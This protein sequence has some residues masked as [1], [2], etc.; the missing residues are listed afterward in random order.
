MTSFQCPSCVAIVIATVVVTKFLQRKKPQQVRVLQPD[1]LK[2]TFSIILWSEKRFITMRM[3]IL[4]WLSWACAQWAYAYTEHFFEDHKLKF[5][6]LIA[7]LC[8]HFAFGNQEYAN[9]NYPSKCLSVICE[10]HFAYRY[11]DHKHIFNYI[12][13]VISLIYNDAYTLRLHLQDIHILRNFKY[14][15]CRI[16]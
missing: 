14:V 8:S 4:L 16:K 7:N 12:M 2:V 1:F 13:H 11:F 3:F 5:G 10:Y 9:A 15:Q 6:K